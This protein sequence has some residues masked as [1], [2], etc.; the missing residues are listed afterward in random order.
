MVSQELK[1]T[2]AANSHIENVHFDANG[3]YYFD[4]HNCEKGGG[5]HGRLEAI[6]ETKGKEGIDISPTKRM[7]GVASTKIV[8]SMTRSEALAWEPTAEP[9]V[10]TNKKK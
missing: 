3:G 5:L 6:Y 9:E 7:K 8:K 4:A 2:I 10:V 1:T